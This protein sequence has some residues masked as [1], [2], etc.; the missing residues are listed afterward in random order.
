MVSSRVGLEGG[1]ALCTALSGGSTLESID[2]S[3]NPMEPAIGKNLADLTFKHK[4]LKRLLLNDLCLGDEGI[5]LLCGPLAQPDS[6]PEL[7]H[8]E[9]SLNEISRDSSPAVATVLASKRRTLQVV[10]LC[11][12]DLECAGA[13]HVA[14][15]LQGAPALEELNLSTN[16]IG[17]VG[18]MAVAKTCAGAPKLKMLSLND[19]VVSDEGVD[20]VRFRHGSCALCVLRRDSRRISM[21]RM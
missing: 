2:L 3:D 18:A 16:M 8:L 7:E 11:E 14:T 10:V 20:E 1:I 17:R 6:C 9:L 13:I 4:G 21:R 19:N 12:N 5:T 15:G